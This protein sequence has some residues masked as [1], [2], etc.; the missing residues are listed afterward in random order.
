MMWIKLCKTI[1]KVVAVYTLSTAK[2]LIFFILLGFI[3]VK[4]T[5]NSQVFTLPILPVIFQ[6]YTKF[7]GSINTNKLNKGFI[8]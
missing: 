1:V 3:Q 2:A 4:N 7:T 5:H 8:L 6:F